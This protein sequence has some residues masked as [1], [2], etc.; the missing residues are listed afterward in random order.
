MP[1]R[2]ERERKRTGGAAATTNLD[3]GG[4]GESRDTSKVK[5]LGAT[6]PEAGVGFADRSSSGSETRGMEEEISF[7]KTG[8]ASINI[9]ASSMYLPH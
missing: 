3:G 6:F 4:G 7:I 9:A 8:F 2:V 1:D 5:S